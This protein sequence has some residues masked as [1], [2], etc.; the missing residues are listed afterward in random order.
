MK[1]E[2][3]NIRGTYPLAGSK[4]GPAWI[5]IWKALDPDR[6][7]EATGLA[8][9]VA[10]QNGLTPATVLG[11]L[12]QARTAGLI[13]VEYMR[14]GGKGQ[15]SGHYRIHNPKRVRWPH[16]PGQGKTGKLAW[17]TGAP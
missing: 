10:K 15:A 7:T 13:E 6:W 2:T 17:R 5:Q 8:K 4:I 11:L 16:L 14:P 3:P 1:P 9:R 12:R